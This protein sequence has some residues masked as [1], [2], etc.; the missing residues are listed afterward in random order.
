MRVYALGLGAVQVWRQNLHVGQVLD[1][2]D[3]Q[4]VWYES[5]S[6]NYA[7]C[8]LVSHWRLYVR[9]ISSLLLV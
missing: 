2:K 4:K 9:T 7:K 6:I 5:L 3:E 8:V 1:A